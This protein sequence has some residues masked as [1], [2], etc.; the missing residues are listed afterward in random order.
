MLEN[1]I[2]ERNFNQGENFK[3]G[4]LTSTSTVFD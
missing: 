4:W 2:F 1:F 3:L